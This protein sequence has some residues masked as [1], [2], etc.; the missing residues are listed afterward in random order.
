MKIPT[1]SHIPMAHLQPLLLE[2][3]SMVQTAVKV[4]KVKQEM[5]LQ[6][7]KKQIQMVLLIPTLLPLQMEAQQPLQ[8][9]TEAM[10]QMALMETMDVEF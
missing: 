10:E 4:K 7:L 6:A 2:M 3:E 9:Q 8:L 1:L 5:E